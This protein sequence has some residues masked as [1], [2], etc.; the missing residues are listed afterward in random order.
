MPK[1]TVSREIKF[2]DWDKELGKLGFV[3][4][5]YLISSGWVDLEESSAPE[6][7]EWRA[8]LN[9]VDLMQFTGLK[10]K[11]GKEIYEGDIIEWEVDSRGKKIAT[12]MEFRNDGSSVRT[13]P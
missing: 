4:G 7:H 11:T 2:R 10:D 12:D 5:V 13:S 8:R 1:P 3:L 9:S 6:D